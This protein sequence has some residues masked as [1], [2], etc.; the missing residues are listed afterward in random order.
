MADVK[1]V[2][3]RWR[4]GMEWEGGRPGGPMLLLDGKAK[5]GASPV[6]ALL[7]AGAACSGI[8]VVDICAKMREPLTAL[9]VRMEG[10]RAEEHPRRF[11]AI[12]MV[13]VASGDGL[14]ATKVRR[15]V[16]LS[17]TKYCSVMLTLAPDVAVTWDVELRPAG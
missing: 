16:E 15:A 1:H 5:A 10:T 17:T 14:D 8:D 11:V 13:F 2:T 7:A 4:D 3:M 12:R 6:E 9:E